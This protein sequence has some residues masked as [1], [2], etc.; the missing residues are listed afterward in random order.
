MKVSLKTQRYSSKL[1]S[2]QFHEYAFWFIIWYC[3]RSWH[4]LKH[5]FSLF[6]CLYFPFVSLCFRS[7][8][9]SSECS[10]IGKTVAAVLPVKWHTRWT[11]QASYCASVVSD[12]SV[13]PCLLPNWVPRSLPQ[14]TKMLMLRVFARMEEVIWSTNFTFWNKYEC[15][16]ILS[17]STLCGSISPDNS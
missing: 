17:S 3:S 4:S 14:S 12:W 15:N 8:A 16:E 13:S 2:S 7:P 6:V 11:F 1:L 5:N 9:E 10:R